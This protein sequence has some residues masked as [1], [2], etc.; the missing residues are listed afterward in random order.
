M[1]DIEN[2]QNTDYRSQ[3]LDRMRSKYPDRNF[4]GGDGSDGGN[5]YDRSIMDTFNEYDENNKRLVD[6]FRT[7]SKASAFFNTWVKTKNPAEAFRKIYGHEA[8]EAMSSPEGAEILARIQAEETQNKADYD[9]ESERIAQNYQRSQQTL[10]EWANGRGLS[11]E[12]KM[13]I[14]EK[15]FALQDSM[16]EGTFSKEIFEAVWKS[17]HYDSDVE[18][19]RHE[20]E[21]TGRNARIEER[22]RQ[23]R[24]QTNMSPALTGQGSR[25]R[26]NPTDQ[27]ESW[28]SLLRQR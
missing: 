4:E 25:V 22:A 8:F 15:C 3:L 2:Q 27:P 12:D 26:E 21:V 13:S 14:L 20:G 19:A 11:D 5:D 6:L 9:A 7:D 24:E 18:N 23:R 28:G 17:D 10:N 1:E 16:N